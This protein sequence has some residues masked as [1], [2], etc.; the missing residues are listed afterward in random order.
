MDESMDSQLSKTAAREPL[1]AAKVRKG[2]FFIGDSEPALLVQG[3]WYAD[4]SL[5]IV[6]PKLLENGNENSLTGKPGTNGLEI[7]RC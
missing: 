3:V 4:L 6:H 1:A 7:D 5:R 2:H